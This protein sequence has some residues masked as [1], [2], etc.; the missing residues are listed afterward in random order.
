MLPAYC[1]QH[2]L[3]PSFPRNYGL[4][5]ESYMRRAT[6]ILFRE[7]GGPLSFCPTM[8]PFTNCLEYKKGPSYRTPSDGQNPGD[9]RLPE[10]LY[11]NRP[12]CVEWRLKAHTP[13][14]RLTCSFEGICYQ[15]II[16]I[17]VTSRQSVTWEYD[18]SHLQYLHP[19]PVVCSGDDR[20][21]GNPDLAKY[22]FE[23]VTNGFKGFPLHVISDAGV[24]FCHFGIGVIQDS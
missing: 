11:F 7:K 20:N 6:L 23:V 16:R 13:D 12:R 21:R 4:T 10:A 15:I 1:N 9:T 5:V 19:P 14:V 18:I 17:P 3:T 24:D 22:I 2:D 8:G